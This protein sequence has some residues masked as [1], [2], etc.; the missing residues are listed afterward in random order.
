MVSREWVVYSTTILYMKLL[1]TGLLI[2][3]VLRVGRGFSNN[4]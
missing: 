4:Q 1:I 3:G 2:I